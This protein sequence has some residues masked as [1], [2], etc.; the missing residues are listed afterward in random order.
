MQESMRTKALVGLGNLQVERTA[1]VLIEELQDD[2]PAIGHAASRA[3]AKVLGVRTATARLLEVSS[4]AGPEAVTRF[5]NALR[6]MDRTQVVEALEAV[7]LT[8]NDAQQVFARDLLS[9]VGG[10]YAFQKLRART[11]AASKYVSALEQAEEKIRSLFETSIMEAQHGFRLATRMDVTV[12]VTGIALICVS[13]VL[14]LAGGQ[15]LDKWAGVSGGAGVLG[16]LYTVL[17]AKPRDQVRDAVDHLMYLKVVF[18]GY[19]RQLHQTDQAFT[20][21]LLDEERLPAAEL[22]SFGD[23]V[24]ATMISAISSLSS[25]GTARGAAASRA[26]PNP[27]PPNAPEAAPAPS[28]TAPGAGKS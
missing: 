2:S 16:V 5:A 24:G 23:M 14:A 3:L 8:T 18:L 21:R 10:Q 13:A 28:G 17:I 20:R 7:I 11:D 12:F 15:G 1:P 19:L 6:W 4:K 25:R 26:V 27:A 22:K 9:E